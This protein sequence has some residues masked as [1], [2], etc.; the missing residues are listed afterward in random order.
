[1]CYDLLSGSI[2]DATID[3]TYSI[4]QEFQM[5]HYPPGFWK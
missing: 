2:Q 1:L 4:Y 3:K 5:L